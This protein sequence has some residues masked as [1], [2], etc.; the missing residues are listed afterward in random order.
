VTGRLRPR[1]RRPAAVLTAVLVVTTMAVLVG[2]GVPSDDKPREISRDALGPPLKD[3]TLTTAAAGGAPGTPTHAETG[4]L[5]HTSDVSDTGDTERLEAVPIDVA[6]PTEQG[7]LVTLVIERLIALTPD[8]LG[9]TGLVNAVPSDTKVRSATVTPDGVLQLDLANLGNIESSLQ[10][11]AV[12]Q[13]VFTATGIESEGIRSV[14][15]SID[16]QP[17]AVPTETGTAT[18]GTAVSRADYPKF[19][20]QVQSVAPTAG[21][22]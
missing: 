15:F 7:N 2:C 10:R 9:L 18:A 11:L 5:V 4:Y 8:Q 19:L 13:L 20:D 1:V 21:S 16:G 12:A 22:G 3:R 14:V 17:T 6:N